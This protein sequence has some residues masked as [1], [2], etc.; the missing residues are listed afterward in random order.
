V[1]NEK[2]KHVKAKGETKR[3]N[4]SNSIMRGGWGGSWD[5]WRGGKKISGGIVDADT[6]GAER[7]L[8][9]HLV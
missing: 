5:R 9:M 6:G 1:E 3:R 7:F 2:K 8:Y 4:I